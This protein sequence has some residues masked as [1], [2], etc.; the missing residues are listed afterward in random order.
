M[1]G[2][3]T[4]NDTT[5]MKAVFIRELGPADRIEF[6]ELPVPR[7]RD[8]E[9]LVRFEASEVNHVDLF[10]RSG[11]YSTPIDFPF[12]IGRD[13]VGTVASAGSDAPGFLP[14]ERVW[15]NS[16]GYDGRQGTFAEYSAVPVERLYHLPE[17]VAPED[18]APLLHAAGTAHIGLHQRA[19]VEAGQTV[20]VGGA[21]GSVGTAVT[22]MAA[23]AGARVVA[24]ASTKDHEWVLSC[25]AD[26]VLD[27]RDPHLMAELAELA[28][29]GFDIW[30][31]ASGHHDLVAC[32]PLM[33]MR[34]TVVIMAGMGTPTELPV[35]ALYTRDL[36]LVGFAISNA[37]VSELAA[38]ARDINQL[39]A[40]KRLRARVGLTL[41]LAE[42]SDS[43][44]M[45]ES[46]G[47]GGRI[48]IR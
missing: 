34:G 13:L 46:G 30:W 35:G 19:S 32:L 1:N 25:G 8:D 24:T 27:Y 7:I 33:R 39:L 47:V 10:V 40:Q 22:Q 44:R 14:G 17:G 29:S 18:A 37:S 16:M 5:T 26:A 3:H 28:P 23:H 36:S 43:H 15:T 4:V 2:N 9:V 6:G 21:G 11:A 38:A 20:F 42:A 48:L 45:L 41:P 31:D 12:V